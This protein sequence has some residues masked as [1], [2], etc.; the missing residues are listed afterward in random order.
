MMLTFSHERA[1]ADAKMMLELNEDAIEV[2]ISSA[3]LDLHEQLTAM[4]ER[5]EKAEAE[6][7]AHKE[8]LRN[9]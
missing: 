5:A 2:N 9:Y 7:A 1:I 4:R 3:Y 6:L 8:M